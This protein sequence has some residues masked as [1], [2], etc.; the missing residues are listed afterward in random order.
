M[1]LAPQRFRL[2]VV[3][4]EIGFHCLAQLDEC[5]VG[6]MLSVVPREAAYDRLGIGRTLAECGRV[7]HHLVVLLFDQGP[8]DRTLEY[9]CEVRVVSSAV[10]IGHVKLLSIDRFQTR[11]QIEAKQ[12]AEREPD[13]VLTMRVHVLAIDLH[14]SAV[15]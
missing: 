15:A 3:T 2:Q 4:Q 6:R 8:V 11:Q 13:G 12:T 1:D 9:W 5:F 10:G 14:V 7:F